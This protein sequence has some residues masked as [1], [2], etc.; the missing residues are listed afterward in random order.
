MMLEVIA[1]VAVGVVAIFF[2][3]RIVSWF[4]RNLS[5]QGKRGPTVYTVSPETQRTPLVNISSEDRADVGRMD[6]VSSPDHEG[7]ELL[8]YLRRFDAIGPSGGSQESIAFV[9]FLVSE[10]EARVAEDERPVLS[11]IENAGTSVPERA[12]ELIM[13]SMRALSTQ[14]LFEE[15]AD[16]VSL[17]SAISAMSA[18]PD[19]WRADKNT[20]AE[21]VRRKDLQTV[22]RAQSLVST[23]FPSQDVWFDLRLG[24]DLA[25]LV[26]RQAARTRQIRLHHAR[27]L[28]PITTPEAQADDG[29]PTGLR[30]LD[31]VVKALRTVTL[32]PSE[33]HLAVEW[34][35]FGYS[36]ES[37]IRA[38][39]RY[40]R[41]NP[42]EWR[43][44]S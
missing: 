8:S 43:N 20:P 3:N 12:L 36:D 39:S 1:I 33:G 38:H 11:D 32:R 4:K 26:L 24:L 15:L 2:W 21:F 9:E 29:G 10:L 23:Y 40:M 28:V 35:S 27:L 34:T 31:P 41:Y 30:R 42:A 37:G 17:H 25:A 13:E 5:A 14:P 6:D 18:N 19:W 44:A 16:H 7:D 22:M